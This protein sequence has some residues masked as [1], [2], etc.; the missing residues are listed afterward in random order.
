[1]DIITPEHQPPRPP[2]DPVTA[3][4]YVAALRALKEHSGLSLRQLEA[5]AARLGLQLSRSTVAGVLARD[6][7]PRE[8]VVVA[9]LRVCLADRDEAVGEWLAAYRALEDTPPA[10]DRPGPLPGWW[11]RHLRLV[12]GAAVLLLV[13]AALLLTGALVRGQAGADAAGTRRDGPGRAPGTPGVTDA[14]VAAGP[15][16]I[17]ASRSGL[18]LSELADGDG[19][20]YLDMCAAAFPPMSLVPGASGTYR[21]QTDHPVAGIGCMGIVNASK[22]AGARA[23][24]DYCTPHDWIEFRIEAVPEAAGRQFRILPTHTGMCLTVA[25]DAVRLRTP[26]QQSPCTARDAEGQRFLIEPVT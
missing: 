5:E 14:A 23:G 12:W 1:M 13:A 3:A 6:T 17:R 11:R 8:D 19:S 18:C 9:L 24:D 25:Q 20:L 10:T 16:R 22:E 2:A 21:I 15:V 7:A 4:G 26:V